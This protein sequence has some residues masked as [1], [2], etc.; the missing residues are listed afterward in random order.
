VSKPDK[1]DPKLKIKLF[2]DTE[3][4]FVLTTSNAKESL[5]KF[6]IELQTLISKQRS[7]N[8]SNA[9]SR[10][11]SA[12]PSPKPRNGNAPSPSS[13]ASSPALRK[14][15]PTAEEIALRVEL[16]SR[17][18]ELAKLHQELVV[19]RYITEEDYWETRKV[20]I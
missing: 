9:S 17:N 19:G 20:I 14:T 2:S 13:G 5:G 3:H 4:M 8:A 18:A 12:A 7:G 15:A 16:L 11:T 6:K 10:V 1:P